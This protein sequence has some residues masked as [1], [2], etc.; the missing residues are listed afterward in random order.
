MKINDIQLKETA[1]AVVKVKL[2]NKKLLL[3]A[4]DSRSPSA[5]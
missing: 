4:C 2:Q 5:F 3:F 1:A